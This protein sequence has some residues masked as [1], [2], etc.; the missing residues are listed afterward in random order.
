MGKVGP[1]VTL[2]KRREVVDNKASQ[3]LVRLR[4]LLI[5]KSIDSSMIKMDFAKNGSR[6]LAKA[7]PFARPCALHPIGE[8]RP[9]GLL[10]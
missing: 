4:P 7:E 2:R 8:F 6:S 9:F 10:G 3:H 5:I 1:R